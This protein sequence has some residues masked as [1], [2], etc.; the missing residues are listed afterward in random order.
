M[1][2]RIIGT[3][4]CELFG[5]PLD[6]ARYGDLPDIGGPYTNCELS[7]P[8]GQPAEL[9][10]RAIYVC[11]GEAPVHGLWQFFYD[12]TNYPAQT[13]EIHLPIPHPSPP[14]SARKVPAYEIPAGWD[15]RIQVALARAIA[16]V[17]HKAQ[18]DKAG[19]PYLTHAARVASRFDPAE[20]PIEHCVGWLHDVIEDT[21]LGEDDLKAAGV[22][23]DVIDVVVALTRQPGM[24]PSEY[25][26]RITANRFARAVKEADIDD[27]TDPRRT[28]HLDTATRTRLATKYDLARRALRASAEMAEV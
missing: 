22:H 5:G 24:A 14:P 21:A 2:D 1:S 18:T 15:S 13:G 20:R 12:H 10:P 25:I 7:R 19:A 16:T 26:R 4:P 23:S 8:L 11:R 9:H 28:Q 27:N 6:G 3:I 17:A